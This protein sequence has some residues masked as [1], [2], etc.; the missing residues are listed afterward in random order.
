MIDK[1]EK[2]KKIQIS[3]STQ[4]KIYLSL[5]F[6]S[7][8]LLNILTPLIADDYSYALNINNEH[9]N[10]IKDIIEY[11]IQH[12]FGW[13]GRTVAHTIGQIFLLF[14]KILFSTCNAFV[15][16]ALVYL[17]YQHAKKDKEDKPLLIPLLHLLMFF[18][19]P[20]FGQTTIW[21]IGSC[22]YL[23]TT[24]IIMFFLLQYRKGIKDTKLRIVLMFLLGIIAGWTNENTAVGLIVVIFL[25][26]I[27]FNIEITKKKKIKYN[28]VKYQISGLI[29]SIVGFLT[30]ILAPGNYVRNSLFVD[31][32]PFI[33]RTI[34]RAINITECLYDNILP[35]IIIVIILVTINIYHKKKIDM[36]VWIYLLAAFLAT[37]AM[38]MSPVFA[39]RSWFG[40]VMFINVAI[41]SLAYNLD[42]YH[43][44]YKYIFVDL[45]I[46]MTI[47]F[48]REYMILTLEI[49]QLRNTWKDR[50]EIMKNSKVKNFEFE[51]YITYNDKNPNYGI[52]DFIENENEW[53]NNTIAKYFD[54]DSIK[55]I[56]S[57]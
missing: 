2:L 3:K 50:I 32:N 6:I 4:I 24:A 51:S 25:S 21:M 40:V 36:K 34:K 57:Y 7:M 5:I 11:Q 15:Y 38:V 44:I 8:L 23:W 37:Y 45:L 35:L 30:M 22:N 17:I 42:D 12:Y 49:N 14:P 47:F 13:G 56:I 41:V 31:T 20:V 10:G 28:V 1:I 39:E 19:I 33:L 54:V 18:T 29:G 46:I 27:L 52:A 16:S 9:L 53:P 48:A 55:G 26:T 43:K